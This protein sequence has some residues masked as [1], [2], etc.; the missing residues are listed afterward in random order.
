M[1]KNRKDTFILL[2]SIRWRDSGKIMTAFGK[3]SGKVSFIAK[4]ALR[5][6]SPFSGQLE[7]LSIAEFVYSSK[8]SRELQIL[9]SS[10]IL[11]NFSSLKLDMNRLPYALAV[12]EILDEVIHNGHKDAIFYEFVFKVMVAIETAEAFKEVFTY[13]LMKISSYLGFRP[14]FSDC[15]QCGNKKTSEPL[16]FL[17]ASG[18]V[19]CSNCI[20][21]NEHHIRITKH[22]IHYLKYLQNYNHR[23]LATMSVC[24]QKGGFY[25]T[26][27]INYL[28]YHLEH[29]LHLHS[30]DMLKKI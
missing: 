19:I 7:T 20:A 4:G 28:N 21:G 17:N 8:A 2:K 11:E 10:N 22:D 9:I 30:L 5:P 18:S 25:Q 16:A 27:M 14:N 24:E 6:K 1:A 15:A 23:Q 3:E 12:I 13:Y 26:L 29:P